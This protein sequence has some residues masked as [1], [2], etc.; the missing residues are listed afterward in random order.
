[1]LAESVSRMAQ[2]IPVTRSDEI[3][4]LAESVS[5]MAQKLNH[6]TVSNV[7]VDDI[8][9]TMLDTLV[10]L[11]PDATIKTVNKA[12]CELLGYQRHELIG[13]PVQTIMKR[14]PAT[15]GAADN[16][17]PTES[18]P[19]IDTEDV[20]VAKDGREISVDVAGAVMHDVDAHR[21]CVIYAARD[22]T[23][24]KRAEEALQLAMTEAV[25][26]NRAKSEFLAN[27][28]HELRTPL[29][30]IIGFSDM[31]KN[32]I[33]V[34]A[35]N[36]KFLEYIL[37][38][39]ESGY[40]LL[41]VIN[42]ILDLSKIEVGKLEIHEAEVDV[43]RVVRSCV[44]LV[45]GRAEDGGVTIACEIPDGLPLLRADGR[46]LKQIVI[47]ILSNAV[48]FTDD[49]GAVTVKTWFDLATGFV[50][51]ITD[52][53][54]GIALEDIPKALEPFSQVDSKL[55]RKYEG[56]G[57]GLPLTKSLIELHGG[58][59]DLQSTVGVGT[60]VTIRFP[61]ERIVAD[62]DASEK[63][64]PAKAEPALPVPERGI[65]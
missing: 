3:G 9:E 14:N 61:A 48:K 17:D 5:R 26:A 56:T 55:S 1:M 42:D 46:K 18:V 64:E 37:H 25:A 40:H 6:T 34:S 32:G 51:Q 44:T 47:N 35:A 31:I 16:A 39:N 8:I 30:A 62:E 65:R 28:S 54:I 2:E 29:N 59:M 12:A 60:T 52:T 22:I 4:M 49:G 38:I 13:Q 27:M 21:D 58:Y 41:G 15:N 10:V 50:L 45:N 33:S 43:A 20:F 23:E 53:G 63:D 19:G 57:L 7:Y 11:N 24:R 36:D